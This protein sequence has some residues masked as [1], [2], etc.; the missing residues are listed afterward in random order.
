MEQEELKRIS[1]VAQEGPYIPEWDSL[2]Q[3]QVP[4]WFR[5]A[6]F[7]I[8][9]HWGL[10][11]IP[12][13][14]NEWYSRNMYR[15]GSEEW[16]Y[17]R[18]V[19]GD[20]T[21]FGYKDFIPLFRAEKFD[22]DQW[23]QLIKEA[24]AR[25]AV[26][27]A[28][29]HDGFQMYKSRI[30]RFNAYDMG[31][32]KDILG[33]LKTAFEAKG[34]QF[35]TSSHRAEHWFFMSHGKEFDSDVREPMKRGDFYWPAMPE[36]EHFDLYST[37]APS[38]EYLEDWLLRTVELIDCYMPKILY[39]DWWIQ[40]QAFKPYL[41]LLTAYYYNRA[42]KLGKTAAVCYKHDALMFGSGIVDMERGK[43]A[44]VQ[45]FYWQTDTAA[46]RNS[47]CYTDSLDYKSGREIILNLIDVVSKK[48]NL[49]LNIGPKGDGSIAP[50]DQKIL[51]EVGDWL[52]TNG[53]AVYGSRPWKRAAE[54]PTVEKTGMFTDQ[55]CPEYT[56]ED[57][58]FTV[59]GGSLYVFALVYP[60]DGKLLIRSLAEE[61]DFD[62]NL[63][64]GIIRE[65]SILG[66]PEKPQWHRDRQGLHISTGTV[67]TDLPAVIK[68]E[69]Q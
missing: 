19:Y 30:S 34:L 29:H 40:H 15:K 44:E 52:H 67:R 9:I 33:E 63:F 10:Y 5:D 48:G 26:P 12:A 1:Q 31:P 55:S 46:A 27:V 20:Q 22:P 25:Y 69:I 61:E 60:E 23:A 38:E 36:P 37:P 62:S 32:C 51:R 16:E 24:G 58:R 41:K 2:G 43:F 59:K 47:W 65:I 49:L 68:I 18:K 56:K 28:E 64:K 35:G 53:E 14:G 4:K 45:P 21:K 17:H 6:K 13:H 54:G 42:E 39:F 11:S 7:G 8:F 66:F 50:G 3:F 57:F